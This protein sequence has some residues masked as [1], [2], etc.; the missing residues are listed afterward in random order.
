MTNNPT[1]Y[2][3]KE[4]IEHVVETQAEG[5]LT[6]LESHGTELAGHLAAALDAARD[7]ALTLLIL[8]FLFSQMKLSTID[9]FSFLICF[10]SG[11][12][13]WKMGRSGWLGWQRLERL[14][15]MIA[16]EKWEIEHH[17][18][19]EREELYALYSAKGFEGKLLEEVVEVLMADGDRLLRVMV[20]E[21][22]NLSLE[23]QEHP[24]K[25]ALGAGIGVLVSLFC[26]V[27]L[28]SF[29]PPYGV[30]ISAL[31][32]IGISGAATAFYQKNRRIPAFVWNT[33]LALLSWV[34][35]ASIWSW[36]H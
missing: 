29:Y 19:Q 1:H 11:W 5:K 14:H 12:L 32:I 25:Q 10:A 8:C 34:T 35:L 7:T 4:A 6:S 17:R 9:S 24:L 21:E 28:L 16:E 2:K 15:R 3:G 22:L 27:P 36:I 26:I 13:I 30:V 20:E 31:L 23:N 33:G 18:D